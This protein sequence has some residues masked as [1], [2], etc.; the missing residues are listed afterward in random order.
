VR[1]F[2]DI[3]K[4]QNLENSSSNNK[5]DE[6]NGDTLNSQIKSAMN[7]LLQLVLKI[8]YRLSI[9][10]ENEECYFS[11]P[12]Y[13]KMVY[14]NWLFDMAKLIDIAAV[15]GKSNPEIV[16]TIITNLFESDKRF[17]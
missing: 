9:H 4:L 5:G 11:L 15:Y 16:R 7:N 1:K 14:D 17:V 8:F 12:Y 13:Q 2:N 3:Y 10:K 6:T